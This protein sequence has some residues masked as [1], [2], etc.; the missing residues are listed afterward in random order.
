MNALAGVVAAIA[1][2]MMPGPSSAG[3]PGGFWPIR[4]TGEVFPIVSVF[5][6]FADV[7]VVFT[8]TNTSDKTEIMII[9]YLN[10]KWWNVCPGF[11]RNAVEVAPDP[12]ESTSFPASR[13]APGEKIS[14]LVPAH[15]LHVENRKARND[16]TFEKPVT[17]DGPGYGLYYLLLRRGS[18][19]LQRSAHAL[20]EV[21][22]KSVKVAP[23]FL[24][25]PYYLDGKAGLSEADTRTHLWKKMLGTPD[26]PKW[27][28]LLRIMGREHIDP[29]S[30]FALLKATKDVGI[31][32][33]AVRTLGRLG[34]NES[35]AD[36]LD[37]WQES[38]GGWDDGHDLSVQLAGTTWRHLKGLPVKEDK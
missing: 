35:V 21:V 8:L 10:E 15:W 1:V 20:F 5:N 3:E 37:K 14:R 11:F 34:R 13:L 32:Q 29:D 27:L 23:P 30:L 7:Q 6:D 9:P 28:A 38:N 22:P 4:S 36:R 19:A 24:T 16:G 31:R 26:D 33:E 12:G 2:P 25:I 17:R 18:A